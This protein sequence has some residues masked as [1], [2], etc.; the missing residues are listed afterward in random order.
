MFAGLNVFFTIVMVLSDTEAVRSG[1]IMVVGRVVV[2]TGKGVAV[3]VVTE[4]AG[5]AGGDSVHPQVRTSRRAMRRSTGIDLIDAGRSFPYN[6]VV[7][8]P[9]ARVSHTCVTVPAGPVFEALNQ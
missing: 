2:I 5:C 7:V 8:P 3:A 6:K 4:I 1:V 9:E